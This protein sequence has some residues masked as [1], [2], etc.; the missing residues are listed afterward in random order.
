MH[1]LT[2]DDWCLWLDP[3]RGV[4]WCGLALRRDNTYLH[5]M[6]DCLDD[7]LAGPHSGL[8]DASSFVMLPY[9]NRIRDGH[10]HFDGRDYQ[11][12]DPEEHAMHGALRKL[13]W[14]VDKASNEH[15][16]CS[17]DSHAHTEAGHHAINWP[18]PIYAVCEHTLTGRTLR[19]TLSIR[20]LGDTAMPVGLGWHPYFLN[21]LHTAPVQLRLPVN[22]VFPDANGDC[23]PDGAAVSLPPPLDFRKERALDDEQ[24]I[25]HCF[26]GLDGDIRLHWPDVDVSLTLSA[27]EPCRFAVLYNP[28]APYF[29]VEPV[30]NANDAF[31]LQNEGIDAGRLSLAPGDTLSA[32]LQLTLE[33]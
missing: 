9:S 28:D 6:P 2:S 32:S 3:T 21:R 26:A 33:C 30:S 18:W 27:S 13:P 25:D 24:R 10:F 12:R 29:A 5:L 31:N 22:A 1:V 19:S 15:L 11:L 16:Q 23:L 4:G 8:L 7:T 17:F 20:N 14:R